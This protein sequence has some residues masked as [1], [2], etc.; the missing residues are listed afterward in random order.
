MGGRGYEVLT[1]FAD[2]ERLAL[3]KELDD[4]QHRCHRFFN[5]GVSPSG[6][7]SYWHTLGLALAHSL[8]FDMTFFPVGELRNFI[9]MTTCTDKQ[10]ERSFAAHPPESNHTA[11]NNST[12]NFKTEGLDVFDLMLRDHIIK[13]AYKDK[14]FFWWRTMLT[15][16]A[17]RPNYG[18]REQI[19]RSSKA[20]PPCM[21]IHVRHSDKYKEAVQFNISNYMEHAYKYK[22]KTGISQIYLMTDDDAVI[23]STGNY[24][25]FQFQYMDMARSN[26]GWEADR[27]AGL[28]MDQQEVLFLVDLHSA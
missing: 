6:F 2:K 19:R 27:D 3:H 16:Y 26:Q 22:E 10:M 21:S 18:L 9:P 11:W 20:L 17:I 8:Y 14:G 7:G 5:G 24:A 23:Q 4:L 28:S 13:P 1:S 12:V 25:D 15:Y